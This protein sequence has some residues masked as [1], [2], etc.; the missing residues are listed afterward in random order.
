MTVHDEF[1]ELIS[2]S[3]DF[4]LTEDERGRLNLHLS[5]CAECRRAGACE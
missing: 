2:A 5:Q 4:D 3:I 1:L